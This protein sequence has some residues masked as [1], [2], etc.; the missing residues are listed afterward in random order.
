MVGF[1]STEFWKL[2]LWESD[3]LD[4]CRDSGK[5]I[6]WLILQLRVVRIGLQQAWWYFSV[7]RCSRQTVSV[8]C[9]GN[10][11]CVRNSCLQSYQVE[12][13]FRLCVFVSV[14]QTFTGLCLET[15]RCFLFCLRFMI[16]FYL[17]GSKELYSSKECLWINFVF[18]LLPYIL[19]Q[20]SLLCLTFKDI[21]Y[22]FRLYL[23]INWSKVY[24][25]EMIC[26]WFFGFN[27]RVKELG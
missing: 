15:E 13:R 3:I 2:K 24:N 25:L 9:R 4:D 17:C 26:C 5:L 16:T 14:L 11:P 10:S 27:D 19:K 22:V 18:Y 21:T 23:K 12:Y 1:E 7:L 20:F 8:S 6:L